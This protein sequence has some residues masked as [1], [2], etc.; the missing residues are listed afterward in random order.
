MKAIHTGILA[1][2]VLTTSGCG[3]IMS[4]PKPFEVEDG[5]YPAIRTDGLAFWSC[6]TGD[7]LFQ[8]K[9]GCLISA[10]GYT[11]IP[12]LFVVDMPISI[13]TDTVMLPFDIHRK[14]TKIQTATE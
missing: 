6:V 2:F 13:V 5:L 14:K 11:V 1:L 8:E 7:S 10:A 12:L 3:T 9:G 4:R